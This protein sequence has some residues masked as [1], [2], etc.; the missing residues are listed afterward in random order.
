MNAAAKSKQASSALDDNHDD[1]DSAGE[2]DADKQLDGMRVLRDNDED[3]A[4]DSFGG[5]QQ[6]FQVAASVNNDQ[7]MLNRG[8]GS[9]EDI[10][11]EL[12]LQQE[13]DMDN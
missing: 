2:G 6:L 3:M 12:T 5:Q 9:V 1:D 7:V 13:L 8:G 11:N 10:P 4:V